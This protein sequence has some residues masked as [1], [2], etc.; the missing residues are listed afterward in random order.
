[1][2][3]IVLILVL[4]SFL[5]SCGG[6]QDSSKN[7]I[8]VSIAPLGWLVENMVDSNLASLTVL[9]PPSTSAETYEPT[10]RQIETLSSSKLFFSIA[11]LDFEKELSKRITSIAPDIQYVEL[12]DGI[13]LIEGSCTSAHHDHNHSHSHGVDPHIWLSPSLMQKMAVKV[14]SEL[15]AAE[16]LSEIKYDSILKVINNVEVTIKNRLSKRNLQRS[17][18]AIVHPSLTYF[19]RDYDLNQIP[20]EVDGKEPSAKQ[21]T[22]MI[23]ELKANNVEVILYSAQT[24]DAVAKIIATEIGIELVSFDPLPYNW[25]VEMLKLSETIARN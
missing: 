12:N 5:I 23:E 15:R 10:L 4:I 13:E 9:V 19:A 25:D 16:L 1:M 7:Q 22:E 18:F 17:S 11:E 14:A 21:I 24:S 3:K 6:K 20:L 2:R 8:V